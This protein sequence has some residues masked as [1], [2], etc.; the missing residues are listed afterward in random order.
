MS[1][2]RDL[3]ISYSYLLIGNIHVGCYV[4]RDIAGAAFSLLHMSLYVSTKYRLI[5]YFTYVAFFLVVLRI[6]TQESWQ[7]SEAHIGCRGLNPTHK[8]TALPA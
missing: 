5:I 6:G 1:L 2:D 7:C 3:D 8:A 4:I